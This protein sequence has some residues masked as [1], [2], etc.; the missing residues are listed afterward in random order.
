M[1]S[2]YL[3]FDAYD[4]RLLAAIQDNGRLSNVEL[5]ERVHLSASQCQR[6][7]KK[8]EGAGVIRGYAALLDRRE[9]GLRVMAFVN[10]SLEKHG[11][12]PARE[13]S[14]TIDD[15]PEVL[16]CWAVSGDSDYLM[17]V[18]SRDLESFSNFLLHELLGMPMVASVRSNILLQR[19]KETTTLPLDQLT[20]DDR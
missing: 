19:I 4:R 9:V 13:F 15:F 17:R 18:V 16:E 12:D 3:E 1:T 2:R 5:A 7:L 20:R 6:R 8:L 14:R 11:T 10:V